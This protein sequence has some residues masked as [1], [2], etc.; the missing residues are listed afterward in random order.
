[1][2]TQSYQVSN[3]V[4]LDY[5]ANA[6]PWSIPYSSSNPSATRRAFNL[7]PYP[8]NPS[9]LF[10]YIHLLETSF[11]PE[12]KSIKVHVLLLITNSISCDIAS[13]HLECS[14]ASSNVIGS[15]I[16]MTLQK[17]I[18]FQNVQL[19]QSFA[20]N[21]RMFTLTKGIGHEKIWFFWLVILTKVTF[22]TKCYGW[23]HGIVY[24]KNNVNNKIQSYLN[25]GTNK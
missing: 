11:L 1:M 13:C 24:T 16:F 17:I 4:S 18:V 22:L 6:S 15:N 5:K 10:N 19:D 9:L 25:K 14:F 23:K 20:L 12:G 2:S 3:N 21:K 7:L 8:S